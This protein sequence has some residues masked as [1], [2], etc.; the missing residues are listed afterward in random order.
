M[1]SAPRLRAR[2]S[3]PARS[4]PPDPPAAFGARESVEHDRPLAGRHAGRLSSRPGP[5]AVDRR[6]TRSTSPAA[7]RRARSLRADG[8]P[9]R[10]RWLQLGLRRAAGLHRLHGRSR[11]SSP[12]SRSARH[13]AGRAQHRRQRTSSCSSQR[14]SRL[15]RAMSPVRRRR[16]STGCRAGRRRADGPRICARERRIGTQHRSTSAK[17]LASTGSTPRTLRTDAVEPPNASASDYISDGRGNVRIM[18]TA[19]VAGATGY[20][21]GTHQLLS[22]G[23]KASRDWQPLGSYDTLTDEGFYP[24]RGRSRPRRR[25]R[26]QE[27]QRPLRALSRSRSTARSAR[28]GLSPIPRSTSTASSGSAAAQRVVGVTYADRA[29]RGRLFRSGAAR[30]S[31]RSLSKAL[32]E[33]AA[34]PFRRFQRRRE[35]AADLGRQRHR[36]RP[37][38]SSTTRR[39]GSSTRSCWSG[40]Q[41]EDVPLADDEAGHLSGRRRHRGARPI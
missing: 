26:L 21:S 18:A 7:T 40:P 3:L 35:Q 31:A 32:P 20:D 11:Q 38:L 5:G 10:L 1:R 13:P 23:P 22:T 14:E 9:E 19:D 33:P 15:R 12:T 4:R 29:A 6:S 24:G 27:A 8:K 16:S 28:A 17:G 30:R 25:L 41:L 39:P 37:L 36:S 34:D 2:S